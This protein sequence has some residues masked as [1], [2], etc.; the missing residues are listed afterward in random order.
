ML[1]DRQ[2]EGH[3]ERGMDFGHGRRRQRAEVVAELV[4]AEC[5]DVSALA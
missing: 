3:R 1:G 5:F 4:L 2:A